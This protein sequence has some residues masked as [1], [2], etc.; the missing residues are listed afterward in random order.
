[1]TLSRLALPL[2][3]Y[4]CPHNLLHTKPQPWLCLGLCAFLAAQVPDRPQC[5]LVSQHADGLRED[6]PVLAWLTI[7]W[8]CVPSRLLSLGGCLLTGLLRL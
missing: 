8:A 6:L 7:A 3:V 5:S 1:M 2:Y 4:G